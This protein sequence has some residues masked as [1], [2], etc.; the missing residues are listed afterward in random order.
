MYSA[1]QPLENWTKNFHQKAKI[2]GLIIQGPK[3][4][5]SMTAFINHYLRLSTLRES[6]DIFSKLVWSNLK[7]H[8]H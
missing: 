8:G 5:D 4:F 6:K 1:I 3:I 7:S 2:I